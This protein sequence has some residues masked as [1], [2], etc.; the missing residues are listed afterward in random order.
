MHICWTLFTGILRRTVRTL[1]SF[2]P[3]SGTLPH[4]RAYI[5]HLFWAQACLQMETLAEQL[6]ALTP[7]EFEYAVAEL[8]RAQGYQAIVSGG[9]NDRGVDIHLKRDGQKAAVQCKR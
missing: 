6:Y 4:R 2:L 7:K 9:R 3:Y 8:F 1:E 5:L